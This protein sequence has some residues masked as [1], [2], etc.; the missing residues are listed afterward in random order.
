MNKFKPISPDPFIVEDQDMTLARFG[1]INAIVEALNE[2]VPS[3]SGLMYQSQYDPYSTGSVN[4]SRRLGNQLPAYYLNRANHTGS[5]S[6]STI[7]G[8]VGDLALKGDMF[9]AVYDSNNSGVVDDSER[10]NNQLASFYLNRVNHT[11]SQDISTIT[12]LQTALDNKLDDSQ[13]GVD[14]AT[15][16]GGVIPV[17][18]LPFSSSLYL[19]LYDASTNTP[20]ILNGTGTAGEFYIANVIGN[21]YAPVNV[22]LVNQ[23]V[24]YNGATWEVGAVFTG[25]ISDVNGQTGPTVTLDLDDIPDTATRAAVTPA[26]AQAL[27]GTAVPA[28]ASNPVATAADITVLT[29]AV[30]NAGDMKKVTYDVDNNGIVDNSERLGGQLPV[31]YTSRTNHTGTQ[32]QSTID[33]LISDLAAKIPFAEKGANSGVCELDV[34]G[35]VPASRLSISALNYQNSWN[36]FTNSP[37]LSNGVGTNGDTYI[38]GVAGTRNLGSGNIVFNVGD[39]VVYNGS[40]W[41]KISAAVAGVTSINA[42]T[43]VVTLNSD[44]VPEGSTN[45]YL[46]VNQNAA[47]DNANSPGALNPFATNNDLTPLASDISTL[48]SDVI[49]INGNLSLKENKSEKGVALGY[50]ELDASG[51]VPNTRLNLTALNYQNSWNALTNTPTLADGVG[52]AGDTY[53]VGTAG[54]QN[55]GSG[56]I[57]FNVG[58]L[59]IYNGSV[60]QKIVPAAAGVSSVNGFTGAVTLTADNIAETATRFYVNANQNAA[61]DGAVAASGANR[62]ATLADI[63]GSDYFITPQLYGALNSTATFASLGINQST[64]NATYPGTG[65]VT[66][67]T[68]DWAALQ[69]AINESL[70]TGKALRTYGVYYINK[71]LVVQPTGYET[72]WTWEGNGATVQST[73]NNTFTLITVGTPTQQET[74]PLLP[75]DAM[76]LVNNTYNI[77]RLK[78]RID[79]NQ[80]GFNFG[81]SYSSQFSQ[82]LV[83]GNNGGTGIKAQ[84]NLNATFSNCNIRGCLYGF[85]LSSGDTLWTSATTS[86]SQCNHTVFQNC[87]ISWQS[88][89]VPGEIGFDIVDSSGVGIYDSIIEG[90]KVKK[91]INLFSQLTTVL[92]FNARNV[93]YE[94][95]QGTAVAGSDEAFFYSRTLGG[96]FTLDN[97]YGQYTA[98]LADTGISSGGGSTTLRLSNTRFWIDKSGAAFNNAGNTNYISDFNDSIFFLSAS[99]PGLVAGTAISLCGGIGCGNNKYSHYPIPR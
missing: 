55:L 32:P 46:T 62:F 8:L 31:F 36:A 88:L 3:T 64:I 68:V 73:N 83:F 85:R 97:I 75:T 98:I 96:L 72:E 50:C 56:A 10:L 81:P 63:G 12:G 54:T 84:F 7:T 94:C 21:A 28:N 59:V 24:V 45:F 99:W 13:L 35:K 71:G 19:G 22:T 40:V 86:N 66:T 67:D 38:V 82:L 70:S 5:Q 89:V 37:S 52:T 1:H 74:T 49:T 6:Q 29:N 90:T 80:T 60:W 11:G 57:T 53:I 91:G 14:I 9:K 65:A 23:V 34:N 51:K 2:V 87:R 78:V 33:N 41:Q 93:H 27:A 44:Q 42:L 61:L 47:V 25:S 26:H 16:V 48:Q 39:L 95:T 4:D 92:T 58:D 17:G 20:A 69:Y 79:T 77:S 43:G 76:W 18:Q 30:S 15:L